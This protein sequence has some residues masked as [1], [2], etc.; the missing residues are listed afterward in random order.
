[1]K[2]TKKKTQADVADAANEIHVN[3]TVMSNMLYARLA[4]MIHGEDGLAS[5]NAEQSDLDE[6]RLI[7]D[8]M[9]CVKQ[10]KNCLLVFKNDGE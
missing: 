4:D 6:A 8:L 7:L 3:K 1:M 2:P 5:L 9:G 10:G